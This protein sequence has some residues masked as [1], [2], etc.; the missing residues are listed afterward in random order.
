MRERKK[1]SKNISSRAAAQVGFGLGT[2]RGGRWT[3]RGLQLRTQYAT[4]CSLEPIEPGAVCAPDG[5]LGRVEAAAPERRCMRLRYAR[6]RCLAGCAG[7]LVREE[8]RA[9]GRGHADLGGEDLVRGRV[10]G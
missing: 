9:G 10:K 8:L 7:G 3:L 2:R 1:G 4:R 5:D 6:R